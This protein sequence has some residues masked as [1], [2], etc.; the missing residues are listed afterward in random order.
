MTFPTLPA[1]NTP[2][3]GRLNGLWTVVWAISASSPSMS[4]HFP[5][6][7]EAFPMAMSWNRSPQGEN[8][9]DGGG[10]GGGSWWEAE[11]AKLG[12]KPA[13]RKDTAPVPKRT[14]DCD[15]A[16]GVELL[17]WMYTGWEC[18]ILRRWCG[19]GQNRTASSTAL[20]PAELGENAQCFFSLSRT[21]RQEGKSLS[22][23]R[24]H[25]VASNLVPAQKVEEKSA[26]R[27]WLILV[28]PLMKSVI[29]LRPM[30]L[31][32]TFT[33]LLQGNGQR[34]E[35]GE[36]LIIEMWKGTV[37]ANC[38]MSSRKCYFL[39]ARKHETRSSRKPQC[40]LGSLL[41][42]S[43]ATVSL[44]L[45]RTNHEKFWLFLPKWSYS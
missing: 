8:W 35:N 29:F 24:D 34:W 10:T 20:C 16:V 33:C 12:S 17:P 37:S 11:V 5:S 44:L 39:E 42:Y 43:S 38:Y 15:W 7:I 14:A 3:Q 2:P 9:G 18:L 36:N 25:P 6:T 26:L 23:S 19:A 32:K 41:E 1:V 40:F 31:S 28:S 27:V 22:V 4:T 45:I 21:Y 30:V 13:H